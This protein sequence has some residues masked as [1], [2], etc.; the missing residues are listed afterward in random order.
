M[1]ASTR[2]G[3]MSAT[4]LGVRSDGLYV[5]REENGTTATPRNRSFIPSGTEPEAG[6]RRV[7][8]MEASSSTVLYPGRVV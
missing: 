8:V 1:I 7:R 5:N 6:A 3:A 2:Y 4:M